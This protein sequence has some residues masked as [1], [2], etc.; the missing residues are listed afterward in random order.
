MVYIFS[1][2]AVGSMAVP[3]SMDGQEKEAERAGAVARPLPYARKV[4][5][6][7]GKP[8]TFLMSGLPN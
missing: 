5:R 7:P 3:G 8:P 1:A 2:A 6:A 4:I